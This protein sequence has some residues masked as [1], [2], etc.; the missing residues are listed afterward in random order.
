LIGEL[1]H[2]VHVESN[3]ILFDDRNM[4]SFPKGSV[5]PNNLQAGVCV[6]WELMNL[7]KMQVN[8]H[9]MGYHVNY[10][11]PCTHRRS[12]RP[13]HGHPNAPKTS[14]LTLVLFSSTPGQRFNW[15]SL[16]NLTENKDVVLPYV[17]SIL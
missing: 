2:P 15:F 14:A 11:I 5:L 9:K 10:I 6:C 3:V 17:V 8:I 13:A 16:M 4:V 12:F 1:I 7:Q